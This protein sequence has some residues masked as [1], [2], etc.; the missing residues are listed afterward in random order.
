MNLAKHDPETEMK[1]DMTP[2]I[3]VVF[4]LII[5][6]MIITDLTQQDLE[7]IVLPVAIHATPD[8]PDP[9]EWR[10]IVNIDY[11]GLMVVRREPYYDPEIDDSTPDPYKRMKEWLSD[12]S[13]RMQPGHFTQTADVGICGCGQKPEHKPGTGPMIPDDALMI[14][15][16]QSTSFR[17]IQ[18]LMEFCGD[19]GVQIWKVQLA[20]AE[21]KEDKDE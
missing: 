4:L 7:D 14:R 5:F 1:M 18:K 13:K 21:N 2:M 11:S 17:H 19:K 16:D 8:T 12:V 15:A 20:A 9:D 6:F 10:P 3:D